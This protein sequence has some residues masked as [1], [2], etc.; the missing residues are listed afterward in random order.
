MKIIKK[1]WGWEVVLISTELYSCK[2]M[3]IKGGYQCSIHYHKEKDETFMLLVGDVIL[4]TY[5]VLLGPHFLKMK[6]LVPFH[7]KPLV[8]HKFQGISKFSV[9][10]EVA[11]EDK[12]EDSYRETKSGRI[13]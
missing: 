5:K 10:L 2:L 9:L 8:K 4:T 11:T 3:V 1:V 12:A 7:I 13:E 6:Q